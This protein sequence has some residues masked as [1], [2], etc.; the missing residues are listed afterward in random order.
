[1]ISVS[2]DDGEYPL[3]MRVRDGVDIISMAASA[4]LQEKGEVPEAQFSCYDQSEKS[5]GKVP[6]SALRR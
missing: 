1:M 2:Y 4:M 3:E 5:P 6:P